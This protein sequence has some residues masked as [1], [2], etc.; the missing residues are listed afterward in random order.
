MNNYDY[1]ILGGGASGLMMAYRMSKDAFFD[2]KK[3]LII[4]KEKKS[5][6][7][8]TWCFWEDSVGEW[9]AILATSWN[10]IEFKSDIHSSKEAILPYQY[11]MIRSKDFYQKM[12]HQLDNSDSIT[13][14]ASS[15]VSLH[16]A[17][18][19]A[20][21]IT[22]TATYQ[23]KVVI[24]SVLFT[25]D[26][27]KQSKYPV[28]QQH[29]V[30]FF[31]KTEKETFNNEVATFMDFSIPQKGNTRFMY[32]LPYNKQEALFEYTLFSENLLELEEYENE[33]EIYLKDKNITNYAITEK[34]QGSIPMTCYPFWKSNSQNI[35]HIGTAGGWS[36]P[37]TG[38]TFKNTS[39]NTLQLVEH[40]K[41]N[42]SL[43]TFHKVNKFWLYDLLLLDILHEKNHLGA[44]LFGSLFKKTPLQKIL[45][46]LDEETSFIEDLKIV[47][48]MPPK[49]FVRALLKRVF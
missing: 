40:L 47:L 34:E 42:K 37:S 4:D 19:I 26:Y 38:F 30:G 27:K 5:K 10:T 22:P 45:K 23:S 9:E 2:D 44:T 14:V 7:D 43:S 21:V 15:V 36:K 25:D 20:E 11:K 17:E 28:L 18:N 49:N 29:F 48:K 39:K 12:W 46:F 13:F 8:R 1:I 33:I 35:V 16:Q 6:N 24:N 3:I 32:V 41:K 31:I